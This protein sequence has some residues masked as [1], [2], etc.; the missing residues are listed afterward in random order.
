MDI[1][2]WLSETQ[3]P[4]L[5]REA[6]STDPRKHQLRD[7]TRALD[8]ASYQK[9]DRGDHLP[10]HQVRPFKESARKRQKG[11][12]PSDA[13]DESSTS[14]TASSISKT[15]S[16]T[17]PKVESFERRKRHRTRENLY[18]PG[19][20]LKRK[21]KKKH[22]AEQDKKAK[23]QTKH[24]RTKKAKN[25]ANP[26]LQMLQGFSAPNMGEGRL[27]VRTCPAKLN[28]ASTVG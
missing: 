13:P 10:T 26:G 17:E 23:Q 3:A 2:A 27:T 6:R 15:S 24:H 16:L 19:A 20:I 14:A 22:A 1:Q 5:Q 18:E 21:S 4:S 7:S 12:S 8:H 25:A 11:L 28:Y 9:S